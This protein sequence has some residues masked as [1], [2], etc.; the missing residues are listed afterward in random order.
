[1]K[2]NS[3]QPDV[4]IKHE[5]YADFKFLTVKAKEAAHT[6]KIPNSLHEFGNEF[7]GSPVYYN[8]KPKTHTKGLYTCGIKVSYLNKLK[9]QLE[10]KGLIVESEF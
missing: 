1:M 9:K 3:N 6:L 10:A 7:C 4:Y 2:T 8:D 5:G